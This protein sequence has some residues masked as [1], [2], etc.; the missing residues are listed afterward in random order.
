MRKPSKAD[1]CVQGHVQGQLASSVESSQVTHHEASHIQ[2]FGRLHQRH[3]LR[4]RD[5]YLRGQ[6]VDER[7]SSVPPIELLRQS[8]SLQLTE[9]RKQLPQLL[10]R[11]LCWHSTHRSIQHVHTPRD[12]YSTPSTTVIVGAPSVVNFLASARMRHCLV[13]FENIGE[14][15]RTIPK[16]WKCLMVSGDQPRLESL[17]G[18]LCTSLECLQLTAGATLA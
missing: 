11:G 3:K 6:E 15:G 8:Y 12:R 18:M 14:K 1:E 5:S 7:E 10:R 2:G 13:S 4:N 17:K 9:A 16:V